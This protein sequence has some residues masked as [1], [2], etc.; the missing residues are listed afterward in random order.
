MPQLLVSAALGH[1]Q[2]PTPTNT[3]NL[4][5]L[6][7]V[8]AED[9]YGGC[10]QEGSWR[11]MPYMSDLWLLTAGFFKGTSADQDR[12][13]S[14]KE[15]KLLKSMKFPP[16]FDKKVD[17]RKVNLQV[18]RP[19]VVK[20]V[21]ELVG[22]EDEVVVEYAM[23]LLEDDSQPT[24]DPRK[25][26][27]NLTG[28]LTTH[29]PTFMAALWNLLL[30]AQESPAGVPKTFVEQKKE[31]MRQARAG[32]TRAFEERD[33][34]ARLDEIRASE[35]ESRQ[36]GRGRGR[37]RGRG[38]R[39]GFDDDRGGR[40]RDGGWGGRGGGRPGFRRSPSPRRPS[41]PRRRRPS[42]SPDMSTHFPGH[43]LPAD[44]HHL[45]H[46]VRQVEDVHVRAHSHQ[47]E[48]AEVHLLAVAECR[49]PGLLLAPL[50]GVG[51][52][53]VEVL[54]EVAHLLA[55]GEGEALVSAGVGRRPGAEVMESGV[56]VAKEE[57][58]TEMEVDEKGKGPE[59]KIKGQA[60]A[61]RRKNK[62]DE[63]DDDPMPDHDELEKRESELKERALRNKVVRTRK[64]ST[65]PTPGSSQ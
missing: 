55:D 11:T 62:E 33:R 9:H 65:N 41:P 15:L 18:I 49:T 61:E 57:V 43:V 7:L 28:F 35:R 45:V 53:D 31:E 48:G 19:W 36:G 29:T 17:M 4:G 58:D 42:P 40:P 46:P 1:S 39:G 32:D 34:R 23:G 47:D 56:E 6:A 12:R 13:F 14:D 20:K 25:M 27:I 26:Q 50:L 16:E 22:F 51:T 5:N 38:G 60:E 37:G 2:R 30:E 8:K 3:H 21:V 63:Q 24:P 10:R 44:V 64:S 54:V 52:A 59:L